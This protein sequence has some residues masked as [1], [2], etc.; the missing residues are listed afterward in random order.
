NFVL[1]HSVRAVITCCLT[2]YFKRIFL[3][4]R[5]INVR[6]KWKARNEKIHKVQKVNRRKEK[7]FAKLSQKKIKQGSEKTGN[8]NHIQTL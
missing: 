6:P 4:P 1:N 5:Q 2:A 7:G 3:D 8:E